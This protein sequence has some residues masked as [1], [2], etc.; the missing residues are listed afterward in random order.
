[1][2]EVNFFLAHQAAH[3]DR[4]PEVVPSLGIH[5]KCRDGAFAK[6]LGEP[7]LAREQRDRAKPSAVQAGSEIQEN[8]FR[9]AWPCSLN[10]VQNCDFLHAVRRASLER[11]F[12]IFSKLPLTCRTNAAPV[13]D[14]R[15]SESQLKKGL[16]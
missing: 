16:C 9:A 11:A 8:G 6:L 14:V 12:R 7:V 15:P 2:D 1:M 5:K 13:A 4:Q 10:R 3:S